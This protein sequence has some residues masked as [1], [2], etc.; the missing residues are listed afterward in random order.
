LFI[1]KF[2]T[3]G[4]VAHATLFLSVCLLAGCGGG[5]SI[6]TYNVSG[7]VTFGGQPV[8]RG[9]I[10]FVPSGVEGKAGPAGTAEIV[11]GKYDTKLRGGRGTTGGPHTVIIFGFDGN[12]QPQNE[13]PLGQPLFTEFK[14]T[15]NLPKSDV[16][17]QNFEA[18]EDRD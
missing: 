13:L 6:T 4:A 3:I 11:D 1:R 15:I 17:D 8:P 10:Q 16:A 7:M 14:T 18:R 12:P 2:F 5:S 9:S